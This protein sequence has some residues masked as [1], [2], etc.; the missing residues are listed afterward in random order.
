MSTAGALAAQISAVPACA[1]AR[2]T[3]CQVRPPP[4]TPENEIE[5]APLGPSE[6]TKASSSSL[7]AEVVRAGEMI[8]FAAADWCVVTVLSTT[9]APKAEDVKSPSSSPAAIAKTQNFRRLC[10]C[11]VMPGAARLA[12]SP[13]AGLPRRRA[14]SQ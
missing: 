4:V 11:P 6:L 3:R 1:L 7:G 5:P 8:V 2:R 12:R 14:H 10:F 9:T 13:M